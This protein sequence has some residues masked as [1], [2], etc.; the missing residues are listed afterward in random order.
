M[1]TGVAKGGRGLDAVQLAIPVFTIVGDSDEERRPW[2][3]MARTQIA[4]YGSTRAYAFQFDLV[5]FD[6][7]SARLNERI[8]A[9]D[10]P[11]MAALI[12]D[13][14]LEVFAVEAAWDTL[15]ERLFTRY[16]ALADRLILYFGDAMR[17]RDPEGFA[18]L[19][20]VAADLRR[21]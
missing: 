14:V 6:G 17:V 21:R 13:D 4:F 12:T 1:S 16:G 8:K 18:R 7:L 15:S 11:G 19:G 10:L 3:E 20:D 2:R 5:G 9:G